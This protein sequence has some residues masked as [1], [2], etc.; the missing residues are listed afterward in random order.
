MNSSDNRVAR[1]G[2]RKARQHGDAKS[3]F[4]QAERARQVGNLIGPCEL[5]SLLGERIVDDCPIAAVASHDDHALGAE[6]CPSHPL[7]GCQRMI[8]A[9]CQQERV[10]DQAG[11]IEVR[12]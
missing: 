6:F 10:I 1:R 5:Q 2:R 8:M 3:G 7:S 4:D 9:A 11:E 12:M